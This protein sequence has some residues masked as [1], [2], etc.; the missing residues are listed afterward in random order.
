M[1]Q[2]ASRQEMKRLIRHMWHKLTE[3]EVEACDECRD[4]FFLAVRKKH[5]LARA[6]AELFLHDLERRLQQPG[7]YALAS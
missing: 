7:E 2:G 5:G 4:I 3:D 1:I 6:Q